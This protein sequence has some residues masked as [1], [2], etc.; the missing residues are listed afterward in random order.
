[1]AAGDS[2]ATVV[3]TLLVISRAFVER[4]DRD[5]T[6][7][8]TSVDSVAAS[9]NGADSAEIASETRR[10][11]HNKRVRLRVAPDGATEIVGKDADGALGAE[12]R[13]LADAR[14]APQ[15][16]RFT[17]GRAGSA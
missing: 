16:R 2:T 13:L 5:A 3:T 14:Y 17:S 7:L 4:R 11:A 9:S 15:H 6:I 1:M 12:R 10:A 8:L